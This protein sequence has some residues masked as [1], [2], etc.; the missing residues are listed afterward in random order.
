MAILAIN[1]SWWSGERN[2]AAT[3]GVFLVGTSLVEGGSAVFA[4]TGRRPGADWCGIKN[5]GLQNPDGTETA[6]WRYMTGVACVLLRRAGN[7]GLDRHLCLMNINKLDLSG[8]NSF[9]RSGQEYGH[10]LSFHRVEM[11]HRDYGWK[12]NR[13]FLNLNWIWAFG[14]VK[15]KCY[16]RLDI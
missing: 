16:T 9:Y 13:Y 10:F 8:L 6:L 7:M 11:G 14:H 2:P 15:S 3:T 12:K 4:Y 5:K 1:A